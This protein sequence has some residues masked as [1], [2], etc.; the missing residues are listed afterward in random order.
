MKTKQDNDISLR[1]VWFVQNTILNNEDWSNNVWSM[2]KTRYDKDVIDRTGQLFTKIE[3][4]LSW[5]IQ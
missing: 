5:P 3:I 2:T 4:E 1:M